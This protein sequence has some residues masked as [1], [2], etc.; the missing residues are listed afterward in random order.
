[1]QSAL[2]RL[3]EGAA[4]RVRAELRFVR[5]DGRPVWGLVSA[6][7]VLSDDDGDGQLVGL[8]ED[9]TARKQA[10]ETLTQQA[11]HDPLTG[12][13]NRTLLLDRLTHAL[14]ATERSGGG[15]GVLYLDLDGFKAVNDSAGHAAGDELLRQVARRLTNTVRPGDT[16]ARLGGD[17]FVVFCSDTEE[18][19]NLRAVAERVVQVLRRPFFLKD[20]SHSVSVSVGLALSGSGSTPAQLLQDAD[21]AMYIAKRAGK[22]RL[23]VHDE[24]RTGAELPKQRDGSVDVVEPVDSAG[25]VSSAMEA[26]AKPRA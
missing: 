4:E 15:I 3:R 8:V 12:L 23:G 21:A 16:V 11:L 1:M 22:D 17:E 25:Q 10:E 6:S 7:W 9:V 19:R 24:D 13:P 26:S 18:R 2:T 20:G 5:P 14:S